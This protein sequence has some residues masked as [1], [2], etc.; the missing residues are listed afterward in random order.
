MPSQGGSGGASSTTCEGSGCGTPTEAAGSLCGDPLLSSVLTWG[1]SEVAL[2][3]ESVH[4][5][6]YKDSFISHDIQGPELVHLERRDL[7]VILCIFSSIYYASLP[8]ASLLLLLI[9]KI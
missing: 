8:F 1:T 5:A 7:K 2:W 6:E 4:M 3:L 9:Y